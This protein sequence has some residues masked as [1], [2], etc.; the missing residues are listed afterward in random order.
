MPQKRL[1]CLRTLLLLMLRFREFLNKLFDFYVIV[2]TLRIFC[3]VFLGPGHVTFWTLCA[4]SEEGALG[5]R[6][7]ATEGRFMMTAVADVESV[8]ATGNTG[9]VV[10]TCHW[11]NLL[12]WEDGHI[13]LEVCRKDGSSCHEGQINIIVAQEGEL[14]TIGT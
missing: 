2:P 8:A 3:P 11:G 4:G 14:I 9:K 1:I 6:L 10:S 5:E 7:R 13:Q 12:V